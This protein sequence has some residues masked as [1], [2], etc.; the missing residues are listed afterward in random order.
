MLNGSMSSVISDD[1]EVDIELIAYKS[2][3][4]LVD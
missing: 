3:V 1:V 4:L 2:D